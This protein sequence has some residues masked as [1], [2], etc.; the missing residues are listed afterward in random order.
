MCTNVIKEKKIDRWITKSVTMDR[1]RL[2]LLSRNWNHEGQDLRSPP[3]QL[4]LNPTESQLNRCSPLIGDSTSG[5]CTIPDISEI[6]FVKSHQ[7]YLESIFSTERKT[8]VKK[9]IL[10]IYKSTNTTITLIILSTYIYLSS[11]LSNN[12]SKYKILQFNRR[13]VYNIKCYK[14]YNIAL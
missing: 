2:S 8:F 14:M 7:F 10:Q 13:I 4:P 11:I 9:N 12:V 6:S 1:D 3:Q 5:L